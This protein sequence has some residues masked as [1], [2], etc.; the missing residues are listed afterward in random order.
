ML[1]LHA[2]PSYT[3]EETR[4]KP[5]SLLVSLSTNTRSASGSAIVDDGIS[6][7]KDSLDLTFTA[8]KTK[9]S[10][11]ISNSGYKSKQLLSAVTVLGVEEKPSEVK[12]GEKD[13]KNWSYEGHLQRLNVTGLSVTL[14][15]SWDI[16]WT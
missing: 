6:L 5:F 8:S 15:E 10:S 1:L 13:V 12:L 9:L 14:Y 16:I 2:K 11:K 7:S 3:T 4:T